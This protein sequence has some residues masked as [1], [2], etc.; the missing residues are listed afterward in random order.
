MPHGHTAMPY[1]GREIRPGERR[2]NNSREG[3]V[4]SRGLTLARMLI[5][6]PSVVRML[7]CVLCGHGI[8]DVGRAVKTKQGR[9]V[10]SRPQNKSKSTLK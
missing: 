1:D 5:K 3:R 6:L 9:P 7:R 10:Y 2:G 8:V 4:R